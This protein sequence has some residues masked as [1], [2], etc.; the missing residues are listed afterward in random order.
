MEKPILNI[1][2]I[3]ILLVLSSCKTQ[4]S[5]AELN[6]NFS[7][8]QIKELNK[9]TE[10]FKAET[11]KNIDFKKCYRQTN[12]DSLQANGEGFWAKL[13]FEKQK[14]L[15]KE[16]PQSVFN[17]IW[18]YCETTYYPN[19]K[20]AKSICANAFGKY[21]NYLSDLGKTNPRIARYAERIKASGDFNGLDLQ[22]QEILSD[23]NT[24]D[25][26]NPNIQLILAV[27]YLSINDKV[28][29]NAHLI[30]KRAE[31]KF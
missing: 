17:E 5:N 3:L 23:K 13:S 28:T 1:I 30:E 22:Y 2:S 11:C 7:N 21:Q 19:K 14:T 24:F 9:I 10:F 16:I 6:A 18:M 8:E 20:K 26:K 31:P 27:H 4:Y 15:Y 25:L 12:H 29:R